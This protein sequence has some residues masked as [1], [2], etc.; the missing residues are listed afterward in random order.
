MITVF[1]PTYNRAYTLVDLYESLLH[2]TCFDFEW[3]IVDDGSTDE[4]EEFVKEWLDNGKFA[5]RYF[6]KLNGGKP[7]AINYGL[8]LAKGEYFWIIDSDDTAT[9]GGVET[10][11]KWIESLPEGAKF[12][13]VGGLRGDKSGGIIGTTFKGT[14]VDAT[15]LERATYNIGGDKSE[16]FFTN[17]IKQFPFPEFAGEKFVPEALVWNRI[18]KAGYKIRW[19]NEIVHI[20][21]YLEDGMTKNVDKN[22]ITNWKGYSLYVKELMLAPAGIKDKVLIGGAY[23]LRGLKRLCKKY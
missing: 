14:Y 3:L 15:T 11:L 2:Q 21:E 8:Q 10:C 16:V 6:K 1:T 22:L 5:V 18:A 7:S 20:T 12:A 23:C 9:P 13:G 4:T 19:F 17:V